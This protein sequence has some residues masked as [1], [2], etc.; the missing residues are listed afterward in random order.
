MP[1]VMAI[2]LPQIMG[3]LAV[4]YIVAYALYILYYWLGLSRFN[5]FFEIQKITPYEEGL[6]REALAPLQNLQSEQRER[7]LKRTA[8]FRSTK[9]FV[10]Y[11][12][13]P[14]KERL[15]LY[16]SA[17]AALLTLG[18]REFLFA[19]SVA[20]VVVYP[21]EYTSRISRK[22]HLGEY[23]PALRTVV[24]AG[25][26]VLEGFAIPNDNKNL[27]IHEL[28]HA[29]CFETSGKRSWEAK[30]FQAG[31]RYL[32]ELFLDADFNARLTQSPYI[33]PYGKTSFPEFLAVLL[34]SFLE[35]PD[36]FE[37]EFP[38]LH[39]VIR[40]MLNFDFEN[41]SWRWKP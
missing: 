14:D 20:R 6:L 30:R 41:P 13:N 11:S 35:T 8:W 19:G 23:H 1:P 4:C 22:R 15:I 33:R 37:A 21:T 39:S 12:N 9:R 31:L 17:T 38:Q 27:A 40:K 29:L 26:S 28:A 5:P 24:L 25:D 32:R 34:E 10:V 7:F 2:G 36:N 16:I 18:M 3:T